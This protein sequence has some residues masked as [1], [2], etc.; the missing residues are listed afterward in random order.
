[1]NEKKNRAG[2]TVYNVS[3]TAPFQPGVY[4]WDGE[5][6]TVSGG[7]GE[8]K[9][10]YLPTCIIPVT[11]TGTQTPFNL[12]NE[13]ASQFTNSG[14]TDTWISS[15]ASLTTVP[16]PE[17]GSLYAASQLDYVITYYDRNVFENISINS[18]G[19]M[20][21]SVKSNATITAA[22]FFNIVFIVK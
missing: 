17:N 4:V 3:S 7:G 2:L 10:F 6:W 19:L 21:Y 8:S 18:A 15:N 1:V 5:K 22:T 11:G 9:Y 14:A 13:Y 16:S 20:S 12:Y